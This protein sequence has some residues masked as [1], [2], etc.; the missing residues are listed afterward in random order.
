MNADRYIKAFHAS[1]AAICITSLAEGRFIDANHSFCTLSG[2]DFH[3]LIG[4]TSM[5]LNL[6]SRP[7]DRRAI[8]G[9]LLKK[10]SI[11]D[12]ENRLIRKDGEARDCVGSVEVI[13]IDEEECLLIILLDITD[14]KKTNLQLREAKEAAEAA[15]R[16]KSEFLANMSHEI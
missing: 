14:R 12:Y 1:P 4:R 8:V 3:E 15:T 6:W 9:R 11:R 2:Y 13:E 7:E 10:R 16:T 5:E